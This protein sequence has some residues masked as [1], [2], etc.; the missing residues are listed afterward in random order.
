MAKLK[1]VGERLTDDQITE[2]I[3]HAEK[4]RVTYQKNAVATG[5]ILLAKRQTFAHG[6]W[7][8][9][10]KGQISS[11][12]NLPS[13]ASLDVYL[14]LAKHFLSDLEQSNFQPEEKDQKV[15]PPAVH[16]DEV[17]AL[18]KLPPQRRDLVLKEIEH[19]VAGRSLRRMLMDF[20]RAE[21]AADQEEAEAA[22]SKSKKTKS[23]KPEQLE[24]FDEMLR[25]LG[26]IDT[27]FESKSF[28]EKT[29]PKF[30]TSVAEKLTAQAKVARKLAKEMA[31]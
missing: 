19:F 13:I 21:S 31:S 24:F 8:K 29:D 25:P 10:L 22:R 16:P 4:D 28:V 18:D 11:A 3:Q 30:W 20:R 26:E 23:E 14:H 9:Y 5:V 12:R 17:L 7:R 2:A 27:L 6:E 1:A 15:T